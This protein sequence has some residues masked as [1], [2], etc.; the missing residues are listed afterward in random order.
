MLLKKKEKLFEQY[1]KERQKAIEICRVGQTHLENTNHTKKRKIIF[2][3]FHFFRA[4]AR[5]SRAFLNIKEFGGGYIEYIPKPINLRMLDELIKS[6]FL[7][8][9]KAV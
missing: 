4:C 7:K 5:V 1:H 9:K 6:I 2:I 8:I 3:L